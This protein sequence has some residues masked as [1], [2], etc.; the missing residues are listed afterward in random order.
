MKVLYII[1]SLSRAGAEQS[2]VSMAPR[3]VD[4]GIDLEV[5]YLFERE[6]LLG[7]LE[8]SGVR[9]HAVTRPTSRISRVSALRDLILIEKPD[10]VHTTLFESDIA[11]RI[12]ARLARTPVVGSLVSVPYGQDQRRDHSVNSVK[13]RAAWFADCITARIPVRFHAI[14]QHV[15]SRMST[16]L[17]IP[18]ARI[19]V[20]PRGRDR[21]SLGNASDNR[22]TTTRTNLNLSPNDVVLFAASRHEYAKGVDLLIEAMP[23]VLSVEPHARLLIAGREGKQTGDLNA[24]IGRLQLE[25]RVRLLGMRDDVPDLLT[26]ADVFV[27]PSRWEGL[28]GAAIEA[29]ALGVPTVAS[30]LPAVHESLAGTAL[31][32]I[33]GD[34]VSLGEQILATLHNRA[35]ARRRAHAAVIRFESLYTTDRVARAMVDFYA[36][37]V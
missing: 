7:E 12:A 17:R 36:R 31:Y 34:V 5:A 4:L 23:A 35:A 30:G 25:S 8:A 14:S 6:G 18:A 21:A 22:R 10:L 2:L 19:D 37:A 33:P 11:G 1:D 3:L 32:S 24:L 27:L 29:M 13:L 9:I 20:I 28:G 15:A 16:T 26:A